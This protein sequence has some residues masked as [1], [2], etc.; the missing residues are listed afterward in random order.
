MPRARTRSASGSPSLARATASSCATTPAADRRPARVLATETDYDRCI[1]RGPTLERRLAA[2]ASAIVS[3]KLSGPQLATAYAT[4]GELYSAIGAHQAAVE[5]LDRA[6][7]S[8]SRDAEVY[9]ILA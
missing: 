2:C 8:G 1:A 3:G 9:N 5:D 4:R 7:A 6:L